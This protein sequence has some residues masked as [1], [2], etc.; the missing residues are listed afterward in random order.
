MNNRNLNLLSRPRNFDAIEIHAQAKHD[1]FGVYLHLKEG[2]VENYVD[3]RTHDEALAHAD[4]L[5]NLFGW[6]VHDHARSLR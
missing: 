3:V 1:V 6:P 4:I 2:G 5:S